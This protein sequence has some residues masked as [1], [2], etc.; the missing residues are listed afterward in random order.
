MPDKDIS[1]KQLLKTLTLTFNKRLD[2]LESRFDNLEGRFDGLE[3]RLDNLEETVTAVK[4]TV[5]G[6]SNNMAT[7]EELEDLK[8]CIYADFDD[9]EVRIGR[10]I[11][12]L[13][14]PTIKRK[15]IPAKA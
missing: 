2:S 14:K 8:D 11:D 13:R 1:N 7:S 4:E 9:L 12:N 15:L 10:R 3:G 5:V 6:I